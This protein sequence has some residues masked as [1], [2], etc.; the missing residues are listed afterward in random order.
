MS[1]LTKIF[2]VFL[3]SISGLSAQDA[4]GQDIIVKIENLS[5]NTGKVFVALYNSEDSF[6]GKGLKATFSTIE[7]ESCEVVFK[8]I[9]KGVYAISFYHDE[10]ENN[11]M[12][13]NFL[14]IPKEDYGCSN[15]AKG[16]MGPPKWEDAKFEVST[17][18]ITQ[19][20]T[21]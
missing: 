18:P 10:N 6:L 2:I 14:G 1:T 19:T 12:D 9:P 5:S 15:N 17:K 7:N 3:L 4:T 8:N 16:F 11:K 20:I 21:L 13:T